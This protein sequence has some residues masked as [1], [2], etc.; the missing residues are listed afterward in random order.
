M[1]VASCLCGATSIQKFFAQLSFKKARISLTKGYKMELNTLIACVIALGLGFGLTY[2]AIKLAPTLKLMDVPKDNRR[3]HTEATPRIGGVAV[4]LAFSIA[5]SVTG[6]FFEALP[7]IVGGLI[8]AT[9]GVLDDRFGLKPS[10][11][12]LGQA[13]AGVALCAF[14]VTAQ[15]ITLFGVT[16]DL[17]IFAYPITVFMVIAVTN[18]I[19]LIDG[20]DGLCTG[21]AIFGCGGIALVS[22]LFYDGSVVAIALT[23]L[24]AALGFLPHNANP[25][26]TFLGDAGSMFFGFML[27]A[28][29]C[30]SVFSAPTVEGYTLSALTALA[31]LGLPVFDTSF[32]IVRRLMSKQSIFRGDKKHVHHRLCERYGQ[33]LAVAIMYVYA[34]ALVG[35]AVTLNISF[36]GEIVGV[37]LLAL[38]FGYA[39]VRFGIY[40]N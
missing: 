15:F 9:V 14:G 19:N 28:M 26:K 2:P 29:L 6:Y 3:M 16:F 31:I 30:E 4:F 18:I 32:A 36:A 40:K 33:R 10:L 5:I 25:A 37:I 38:A 23:L 17:W 1:L 8:I 21:I 12:I 7:Y 20:V 11:K 22:F 34:I 24:C 13:L 39:T 27:T 35:I